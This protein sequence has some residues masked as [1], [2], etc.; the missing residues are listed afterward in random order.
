LGMQAG[1]GAAR[2]ASWWRRFAQRLG[3]KR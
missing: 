1:G 2:P 3:G